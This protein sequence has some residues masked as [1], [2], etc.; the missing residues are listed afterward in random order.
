MHNVLP[1]ITVMIIG[2]YLVKGK[3]V[4]PAYVICS[5][6]KGC[7]NEKIKRM[8]VFSFAQTEIVGTR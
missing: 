5:D 8:F 4:E 7:I 6:F 1:P 2:N 3:R